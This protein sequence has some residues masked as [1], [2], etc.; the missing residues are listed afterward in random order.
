[1]NIDII[2]RS[3]FKRAGADE[4]KAAMQQ[5]A[6]AADGLAVKGTEA[7]RALDQ[8]DRTASASAKGGMLEFRRA[9]GDAKMMAEAMRRTLQGGAGS[10]TGLAA[11]ARITAGTVASGFG[12]GGI[13][14][15][16]LGA[17]IGLLAELGKKFAAPK[18]S[19][20]DLEK[21]LAKTRTEAE[22][23]ARVQ[24]SSLDAD[25]DRA[26]SQ[27]D[28][29]NQ[30]LT[31]ALDLRRQS[32]AA[33]TSAGIAGVFA[34]QAEGRL[35]PDQ[36][37]EQIAR[38]QLNQRLAEARGPAERA[39]IETQVAGDRATA[40]A[41][42]EREL[43]NVYEAARDLSIETNTRILELRKILEAESTARTMVSTGQVA[44]EARG[45]DAAAISAA[46]K[47]IAVNERRAAEASGALAIVTKDLED[48]RKRRLDAEQKL[49]L[50]AEREAA[51]GATVGTGGQPG[52]IVGAIESEAAAARRARLAQQFPQIAS[53]I[54][55]TLTGLKGADVDAARS[56]AAAF[57][58]MQGGSAFALF[59]ALRR[60]A[61]RT[62]L[63]ADQ[64][65]EL[66]DVWQQ[67]QRLQKE[68]KAA[69]DLSSA[70]RDLKEATAKLKRF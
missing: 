21:Q 27:A 28:Q 20:E 25:F 1:M 50:A 16:A 52:T 9:A 53:R 48:A 35:A 8:T 34:A 58:D 23:L 63:T 66:S 65:R 51:I 24:L 39:A 70:A 61:S 45:A 44:F 13:V 38:L 19:A 49:A 64:R 30:R 55:S 32:G 62:D 42:A 10:F 29:L 43:R 4:A 11:A 7:G 67:G 31:L 59:P 37:A 18:A 60:L 69:E 68:M 12:V 14:A 6:A 17:S 56:A 33:Q 54:T 15:L 22:K 57:G 40:A 5:T 46:Q 3:L 2:I 41:D 36:A 47:E 26:I